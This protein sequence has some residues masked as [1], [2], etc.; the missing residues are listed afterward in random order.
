MYT[1]VGVPMMVPVDIFTVVFGVENTEVL[2][3]YTVGVPVWEKMILVPVGN[4]VV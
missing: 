4:T 2:T 1:V 3:V